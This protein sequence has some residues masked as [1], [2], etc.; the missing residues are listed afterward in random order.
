MVAENAADVQAA[1]AFAAARRRP[2]LVK[3]TGHQMVGT[4]RG[5]VVIATHRMNAVVIDAVDH[6]ARVGAGAPR[7]E[8]VAAAFFVSAWPRST[9][10]IPRSGSPATPWAAASARPSSAS[11]ATPPTTCARWRW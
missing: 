11:T 2:V 7:G 6:T 9:A 10:R 8:V 5:A 3:T 1:V 4:A